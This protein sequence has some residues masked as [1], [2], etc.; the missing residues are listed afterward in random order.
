MKTNK[1]KL[2]KV[3]KLEKYGFYIMMPIS[4]CIIMALLIL[5]RMN[6]DLFLKWH[7]ISFIIYIFELYLMILSNH[8]IGILKD[9]CYDKFCNNKLE[10]LTDKDFAI[11]IDSLSKVTANSIIVFVDI[12][13]VE[14]PVCRIGS[15]KYVSGRFILMVLIY[16]I[17]T[18]QF[19]M[20][21]NL[22][23]KYNNK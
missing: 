5:N 2:Q 15:E 4:I 9:I 11:D 13:C 16:V 18:I 21:Q 6:Q 14:L 17:V 20:A 10:P 3:I 23:D 8:E 22:I 1:E 12:I 7:Y 19:I